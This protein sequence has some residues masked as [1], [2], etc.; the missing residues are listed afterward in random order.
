MSKVEQS[1]NYINA[2]KWVSRQIEKDVPKWTMLRRLNERM[3][4]VPD[5]LIHEDYVRLT[6]LLFG[7]DYHA[8]I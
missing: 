8:E 2:C 5:A 4:E 7:R 1:R 3:N 6:N